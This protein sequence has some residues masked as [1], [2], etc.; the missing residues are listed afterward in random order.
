[1][2]WLAD[3]RIAV[4]QLWKRPAFTLV[5]AGTLALGIG[6][7]TALFSV[8]YGVLISPYPYA[9]PGEIWAP[10]LSTAA[11]AQR[12]RP[13]RHDAFE[14]MARQPAFG[15]V[16]ATA[17]GSRLLTGGFAP[18]TISTI[19]VSPNA[20]RFLG[21]APVIGRTIQPADVLATG[22]AR[23]VVVLSFRRWQQAFAG[24]AD[25]LGKTMR[26]DDVDHQVI[27]VMPPRF[28][29][30]TSD[31]VWV[32]LARTDAA[33]MVFPIAR[34]RDGATPE[35]ATQQ[36]Q[37]LVPAIVN[38][39][40]DQYPRDGVKGILTN[41]LD[42]T[43][44]SGP[45]QQSLRLLFGA[46]G[47][48]LLIACANVANL[49][50]ARAS[51]RTREIAVRLSIGAGRG[52][53]VRQLLTESVVLALIG[54]LAGLAFAYVIIEVM[55]DLMPTFFVPNEARI[56]LNTLALAFCTG[57]SVISGIAF[58]LA[59]ALQTS[60]PDLV[61]AL[62]DEAR[63]SSG[64]GKDTTRNVLVV[65]EVAV[66]VVL[67][68]TAALTVRSFMT[69]QQVSLG[70][71]PE[72]MV[73]VGVPLPPRTYDT[74]ES[75]D[76]FARTLVDRVR[77][78]P[79]VDGVTIGNGGMPFG[80]PESPYAIDGQAAVDGQRAQV[81]L[82][83]EDYWR[84]LGA[85]I[86]RGRGFTD[87]EVAAGESAG[88]INE[89]FAKL[90]PPGVD[91][92]GRRVHLAL[93]AA[94]PN[95]QVL[96]KEGVSPLVTI[97]GV[98]TDVRNEGLQRQPRPAIVIPYTLLAPTGRTLTVR[99]SGPVE[100]LFNALRQQALQMDP[101]LP[102]S[103]PYTGTEAIAEQTAQ[104]RFTMAL[105]G[106]FGALGLALAMAGLYSVLSYLVSMRRREIGIRLALGAQP[107]QIRRLFALT[108]LGLVAAGLV[109]GGIGSAV[110][111]RVLASQFDVFGQ[112]SIDLLSLGSVGILLGI[113]ALAACVLPASRAAAVPP[114]ESMR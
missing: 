25:V 53:I 77:A 69:L 44:A 93:L 79:Q 18:E 20:F 89:A 74:R 106:A 9:R 112:T 65:A 45:M 31:G 97:V 71:E 90:F 68:V 73:S 83:G 108:G 11:G 3:V 34:L 22:E 32:P 6:A 72:G 98:M 56:E 50:L 26:L 10:G 104:P 8:V 82:A 109:A 51:S 23:P 29:W 28:G 24:A 101:L 67:L 36:W 7:A 54:G 64:G 75:R 17:P 88:V 84:V 59:P 33:M 95:P 85:P 57:V 110:L 16:M 55:V 48:L 52:Q 63:G 39:H 99:T 76:R 30:W 2:S 35:V 49:Q 42:V 96:L 1:M 5:A 81:H 87:R 91:P 13:Y 15:D 58:G 78:L 70:F 103:T 94:P 40:P 38:A 21:V 41:Y 60:R 43:V 80:G 92:V 27:G 113:A 105:F 61:T 14:E 107:S 37:A 4:R 46:V 111:A 86:R 102:L 12:V 114:T 62:K 19:A 66:S 47:L 100:P